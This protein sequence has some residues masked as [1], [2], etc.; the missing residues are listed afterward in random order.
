LHHF[1]LGKK[2]SNFWH[3]PMCL[4][5][6]T[7]PR[8]LRYNPNWENMLLRRAA[9]N[10][11]FGKNIQE[12][13]QAPGYVIKPGI[14]GSYL[15]NNDRAMVISHLIC[16]PRERQVLQNALMNPINFI[17]NADFSTTTLFINA[18]TNFYPVHVLMAMANEC[19]VITPNLPELDGII[20]H[21][22]NGLIYKDI[23][24][25]KML[26]DKY[27]N[28]PSLCKEIGKKGKNLVMDTFPV[29]TFR[30]KMTAALR[31]A[32]EVIYTR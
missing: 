3:I 1:E 2:F 26:I 17:K 9:T 8:E 23:H 6:S 16:D 25:L 31:S 10:I 27:K 32:S 14:P 19:C 15:V 7:C 18:T 30:K 13:W 5:Q 22:V 28:C 11:Y 29:D 20:E 24:E 21:E 4:I 12:E